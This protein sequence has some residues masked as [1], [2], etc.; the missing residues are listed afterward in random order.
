[1][2]IRKFLSN[3][4]LLKRKLT[5]IYYIKKKSAKVTLLILT[6]GMQEDFDVG[7]V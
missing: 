6:F 5:F 2:K 4:V 3:H 1:M 7:N